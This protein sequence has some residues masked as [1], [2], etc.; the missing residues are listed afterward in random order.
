MLTSRR[1]F[2]TF[3]QYAVKSTNI[4]HITDHEGTIF[5]FDAL[6]KSKIVSFNPDD[7]LHFNKPASFF[8]FGG[9]ATDR[10]PYDLATT[11]L[12][13]DFKKRHPDQVALLVGNRE[14]K[15]NRFP[16]EL[17][18]N[19]IRERLL[20][21]KPP[22]WLPANSQTT[23]R[24]YLQSKLIFKDDGEAREYVESLSIEECQLLYL[25]WMLETNMGCPST[26]QYR[27]EELQRRTNHSVTD[28]EVLKSFL[29]ETSPTGLMGE[30][31]KLGQMG[32]IVPNTRVLAVHGGLTRF[33][34]GRI[35][36]MSLDET[37]IA[38]A[39]LWLNQLNI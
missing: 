10:G 30:Y 28:I 36:G 2:S 3:F 20:Y 4:L 23:P 19:L 39:R 9:D 7:G 1:A 38:D 18:P 8:I 15:N 11:E 32:I 22:R 31:L 35:P 33:N 17:A 12:L 6:K 16:I 37:P 26:F 34:I 27:R 24:D 14:I 25:H 13:V 29:T 21:S 5:F